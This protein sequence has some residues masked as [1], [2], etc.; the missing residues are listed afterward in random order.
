MSH[1]AFRFLLHQKHSLYVHQ[2]LKQFVKM[3]GL[4][5]FSLVCFW[6]WFLSHTLLLSVSVTPKT[7][8]VQSPIAQKISWKCWGWFFFKSL[9]VSKVC[10]CFLSHTLLL[11]VSV[12]PKT[13]LFFV[14]KLLKKIVKMLGLIFFQF[15]VCLQS[16]SSHT[17]CW[18]PFPLHQQHSLYVHKFSVE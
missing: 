10:F 13:F 12:T 8:F 16:S 2:L 14:H 7:F 9:V 17:L 1:C 3:L 15:F 11:F 6:F 18:F 4:I 5:F